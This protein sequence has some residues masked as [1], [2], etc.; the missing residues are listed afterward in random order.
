MLLR[1]PCLLAFLVVLTACGQEPP[2]DPDDAGGT[3]RVEIGNGS[4]TFVPF[5]DGDTLDLIHG[6]QGAQHIWIALRVWGLNPRG[7]I[8]DLELTRERDGL[9]VSQIFTVRVSLEPVAGTDYAEVT[10]LTLIVPEPDQAIGEDLTLTATVTAMDGRSATSV[11][12][13]RT[14]WGEGGCL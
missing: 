4:D 12:H 11:R 1:R 14:E 9:Q 3:A 7:T 10:G 6:C 2:S 13:I 8:L 5:A